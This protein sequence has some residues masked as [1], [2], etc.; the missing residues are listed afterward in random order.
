MT[1]S[2]KIHAEEETMNK[3]VEAV[4]ITNAGDPRIAEYVALRDRGLRTRRDRDGVF[5]GEAVLVV[6]IMLESKGLT[7]SVLASRRQAERMARMIADSNSPETPLFVAD[8]SIIESITG[9]NMHRGIL[10]SGNRG[11]VEDRPLEDILPGPEKD[12]TLLLCDGISN[13]D[14]IGMMFRNAAAF[15]VDA[16]ILSPECHDPL[17]RKSL[18]VSIGHALRVPWHRSEDW[19]STLNRLTEEHGITLIG[20]SID[21]GSIPLDDIESPARVGVVMGGE[22][23]GMG[24]IATGHCSILTRIPMMEGTDSLNVGVAAAVCLHKFSRSNRI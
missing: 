11:P 13:I 20:T 9:F 4:H 12:A 19:S 1:G 10:A 2:S 14:N 7:R 6:D 3:P 16:V 17:Y 5:I 22:F 15:G 24:Q 23:K 18:R 21:T 8:E